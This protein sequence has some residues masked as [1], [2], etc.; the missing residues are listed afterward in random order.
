MLYTL[1]N[2]QG[3]FLDTFYT[4]QQL[5]DTFYTSQ[6]LFDT[7]YTSQQLFDTFYTSQFLSYYVMLLHDVDWMQLLLVFVFCFAEWL[8]WYSISRCGCTLK[9]AGNT[10]LCKTYF[11]LFTIRLQHRGLKH[12]ILYWL[13]NVN[14]KTA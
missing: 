7:F 4:S 9:V 6:Q 10:S 3:Q 11:M 5:F 8:H 1:V 2:Q 13:E 14:L 12:Y